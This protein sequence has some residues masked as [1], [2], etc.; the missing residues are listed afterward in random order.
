MNTSLGID[1]GTTNSTLCYFDGSEYHYANLEGGRTTIP[2]L[3]YVDREYRP[4]YG[5]EART[6]FLEDNKRRQI[7]LEKTDLGYIEIALGDGALPY[8]DHTGAIPNPD[9]S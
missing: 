9:G 8:F 5:E 2:S 1:F 7:K 6:R 4:T 3:M